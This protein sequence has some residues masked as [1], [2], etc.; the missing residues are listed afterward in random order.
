MLCGSTSMCNCDSV[1]GLQLSIACAIWLWNVVAPWSLV[2]WYRMLIW[3]VMISETWQNGDKPLFANR[4]TIIMANYSRFC[5]EVQCIWYIVVVYNMGP[6]VYVISDRHTVH[7]ECWHTIFTN[8]SYCKCRLLHKSRQLCYFRDLRNVI[9][10]TDI[11]CI[12]H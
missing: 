12:Y 7:A 8:Y 3:G 5:K 9:V 6:R 10:E 1:W 4:V 2:P 11:D